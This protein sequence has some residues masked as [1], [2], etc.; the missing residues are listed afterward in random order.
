MTAKLSTDKL[1]AALD[2]LDVREGDVVAA[3]LERAAQLRSRRALTAAELAGLGQSLTG[4][5]T[6]VAG[7]QQAIAQAGSAAPPA[8]DALQ[9]QL[10]ANAAEFDRLRAEL[11]AG[12]VALEAETGASATAHPTGTGARCVSSRTT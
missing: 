1:L 7:V 4:L 11:R 9:A 12:I 3:L 10:A 2:E 6:V 5:V 8:L